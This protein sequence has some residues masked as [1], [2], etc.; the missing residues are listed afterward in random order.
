MITEQELED[1]V[2]ERIE[3]NSIVTRPQ[4]KCWLCDIR[5]N[6]ACQKTGCIINGGPCLATTDKAY[7]YLDKKGNPVEVSEQLMDWAASAWVANI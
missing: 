6:G 3:E 5:R 1:F 7:A 2:T 4:K